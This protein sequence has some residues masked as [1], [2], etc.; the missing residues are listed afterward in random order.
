MLEAAGFEDLLDAE[1]VNHA[2]ALPALAGRLQRVDTDRCWILDVAHNPA[3][4]SV[5]ADVLSADD[6]SGSTVAIIALLE[7]KDIEGVVTP[8]L[9]QVDQWIAV[10]ADNARAIDASEIGR[11]IACLT[12]ESCFAAES[13]EQAME[14]ARQFAASDDRILVTGSFYLVGP[15]LKALEIYSAG[16]GDT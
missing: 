13:L 8:L 10:T 12:N 9:E 15:V 11:N 1:L 5:L 6:F 14:Q 4:A 2:F 3:A 16:G 7:D